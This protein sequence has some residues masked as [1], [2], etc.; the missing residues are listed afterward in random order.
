MW[1]WLLYF[2]ILYA[3]SHTFN[4]TIRKYLV[5]QPQPQQQ[6]LVYQLPVPVPVQQQFVYQPPLQHQFYRIPMPQLNHSIVA[7]PP[8]P[9][10]FYDKPIAPARQNGYNSNFAEFDFLEHQMSSA[11]LPSTCES[12][13]CWS[14]AELYDAIHWNNISK[15]RFYFP[16]FCIFQNCDII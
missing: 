12:K 2:Q 8:P 6:H 4:D 9:H 10:R 14:S 3:I 1:N 11:V 5:Y 13:G 15:K 16:Y 7:Q